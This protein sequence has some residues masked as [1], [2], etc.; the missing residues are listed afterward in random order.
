MILLR[1]TTAIGLVIVALVCGSSI[2][3]AQTP[4][5]GAEQVAAESARKIAFTISHNP[6]AA[7]SANPIMSLVSAISRDNVV[8]IKYVMKDPAAFVRLKQ[9]ADQVRLGKTSYY[10]N[11]S[12]ISYLTQG[13]VFHDITTSPSGDDQLEISV[14]RS[15]C[16]SLPKITRLAPSSLAKLALSV[17]DA[18][19]NA[20]T[21]NYPPNSIL[22]FGGASAHE[23]VVEERFTLPTYL[24]TG[25]QINTVNITNVSRGFLCGEYRSPL[26]QGI[27]FHRM[28]VSKDGSLIFDFAVDGS[29]C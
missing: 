5:A 7:T 16:D 15:S 11:A 19:N 3:K 21:K 29:N 9:N 26:L 1:D 10:C 12:R 28:Y 6:G 8:E 13:V 18:E 25:P 20:S 22:Q 23:G 14:D 4:A 24:P 2:A 27:T 17:A